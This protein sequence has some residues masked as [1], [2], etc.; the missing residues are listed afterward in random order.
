VK[1][2][3]LFVALALTFSIAIP[4]FAQKSLESPLPPTGNVTLSLDEY[5][6]LLALANRPGKK[7]DLPPLPYILKR[8]DLKFR[9]TNDD[10]LGSVQLEGETL[11]VN[12]AKVP[13]TT[14]MTVLDAPGL[15]PASSAPR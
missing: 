7:S 8:A 15:P 14:G 11:G 1:L 6:R 10:V 13:L 9:V 4:A 2:R 5:N 12:S 3:Q